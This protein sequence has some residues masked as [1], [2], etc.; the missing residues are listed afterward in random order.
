[1]ANVT[2]FLKVYL[3]VPRSQATL[4]KRHSTQ[5]TFQ[6]LTQIRSRHSIHY[7]ARL[8]TYVMHWT[9]IC[10]RNAVLG[11]R[12][13]VL[14]RT[15][16]LTSLSPKMTYGC[17]P[18]PDSLDTMSFPGWLYSVYALWFTLSLTEMSTRNRKLIMLGSKV[19]PVRRA[20]NLAAMS[21]D[22]LDNVGSLT[23]HNPIGLHG[24]LQG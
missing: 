10:L 3:R 4:L 12:G 22:C 17:L 13:D 11:C 24:L 15:A 21:T 2:F 1:M 5:Q 9:V 7:L 16:S 8:W 6:T 20:D 19:R 18:M 23:S 14:G